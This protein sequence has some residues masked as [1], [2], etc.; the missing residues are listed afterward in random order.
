MIIFTA[1]RADTD[2]LTEKLNKSNLKAV[3]LS[4]NLNQTQ[5]NTIMSQFERTVFKILVTTD[6]ASRGLDIPSV[7]HVINFDMPNI[8]K[9][10][11]T[12]SAV[13]VVRVT[14]AM[15]C[16]WLGLKIGIASNE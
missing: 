5:R 4:G 16:H 7:T 11:F 10:T 9:S 3:A 6:V 12:V 13:Q 15:R 14:K 8:R 1:T 2:R